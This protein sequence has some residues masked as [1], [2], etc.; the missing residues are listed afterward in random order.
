MDTSSNADQPSLFTDPESFPNP[1]ITPPDV[2]AI[3]G[4]RYIRDFID[5]QKHDELL[6]QIDASPWLTDLK[7]RV[8]HYGY[9]YDY[10]SR[11]VN[12]SMR[13]GPL[14]QWAEELA[15]ILCERRLTLERPDQVIVNEYRPGQGIA[16]HV[17]CVPC[18][19]DT[20]ISLSLGSP[21]VM[22][23]TNKETGQVLPLL[24]EPRSLFIM[25]GE[26]RFAWMHGIPARKTDKYQGRTIQRGRRVSL[27]FRKVILD[28]TEPP[29][30]CPMP[31]G[32]ETVRERATS[33]TQIE[34]CNLSLQ[35]TAK[36][37]NDADAVAIEPIRHLPL[38]VVDGTFAICRLGAGATIPAWTTT[39]QIFSITRTG[40]ELSVVCLQDTVPEGV[41]CERGWRCIRVAGAMPFTLVGVL[42][43][44]TGPVAAAGVGVFVV[45]T[46]DTD[47]LFVKEAEFRAAVAALRGAGHLVEGVTDLTTDDG[48]WLRPVQPGDLPRMYAMQLDPEANR[49]AVTIPRT[50]EA[51]DSHWAKALADP[52]NTTRAVLVGEAMVGY[53][54][55]FPMDDQDH[56]GY[57]ID[58]AY[59]GMGIAS[60]ALH[61]LLREVTKRPLVASAATSNGA[62]LRVL[63]KCGFVIEQ[64][65]LSPASERYP[66]CEEAVLVLR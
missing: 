55:C 4:L 32:L 44:L 38:I 28:G 47:Y 15:D 2:P 58:R 65:R 51:F 19:T 45:S 57:W 5:Q 39:S 17:D 20:I 54:S 50:G 33:S 36:R 29:S 1:T 3:A 42:A 31:S 35:D 7:R 26:A 64:V 60:R 12:Y 25:Q 40:D 16:S 8:Q 24:V 34:A 46:F 37:D 53:I 14:P 18:F 21:C 10:K 30:E 41:Q 43:S 61:Q 9:K 63:Q 59:W 11:S 66:E 48:V 22:E 52:G 49:M 13:I 62:S 27:T 6:C 23:F 56:V